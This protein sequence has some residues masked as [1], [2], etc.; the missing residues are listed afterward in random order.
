MAEL[1]DD[2]ELDIDTSAE[3]DDLDD[4]PEGKLAKSRKKE[5]NDPLIS[6]EGDADD[7]DEIEIVDE[8][9]VK[10]S[11]KRL[12]KRRK[13]RRGG[14]TE[15]E[16]NLEQQLA[17]AKRTIDSRL[18]TIEQ[19]FVNTTKENITGQ[20]DEAKRHYNTA[21]AAH[22]QAIKDGDGDAAGDAIEL[23][24]EAREVY[25]QLSNKKV[26]ADKP[27]VRKDAAPKPDPLVISK[28]NSWNAKNPWYAQNLSNTES[29]I[30]Y[31]IDQAMHAEGFDPRTE[32]YWQE[33]DKRCRQ[34]PKLATL[35]DDN[36]DEENEEVEDDDEEEDEN[37]R[38]RREVSGE[39]K[40]PAPVTGRTPQQSGRTKNKIVLTK[41]R[42]DAMKQMGLEPGTPGWVKMAKRYA[43]YDKQSARK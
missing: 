5:G 7:E 35:M 27:I 16:R 41:P 30:A 39:R 3:G 10:P 37:P 18:D 36:E 32:K 15:R 4:L 1:D 42:A 26:A 28:L 23:M 40:K 12:G 34:N 19:G 17:E 2:N 13:R 6:V 21:K 24:Q 33:L 38:Q 8:I 9:R 43:A 20:M 22:V 29:R 14:S 11:E 25:T 31:H